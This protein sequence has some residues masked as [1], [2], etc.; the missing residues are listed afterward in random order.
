MSDKIEA[1][2]SNVAELIRLANQVVGLQN[3][4]KEMS[5]AEQ[6]TPVTFWYLNEYIY[7]LFRNLIALLIKV[8]GDA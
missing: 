7:P 6:K 4:I 3:R 5:K 2:L 1:D 8:I